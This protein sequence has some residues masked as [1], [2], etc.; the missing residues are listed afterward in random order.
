MA[1]SLQEALLEVQDDLKRLGLS[2]KGKNSR[3]RSRRNR[4]GKRPVSQPPSAGHAAAN[5]S[6]RS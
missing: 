4:R 3:K 6:Q 1:K 5:N 2:V